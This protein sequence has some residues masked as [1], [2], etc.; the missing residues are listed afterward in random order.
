M[1][2]IRGRDTG[3]ERLLRREVW[4]MGLRYRLQHRIGRTR[5]DLV[6]LGARV[7]VFVDGCFWHGCPEHYVSPRSSR[8]FWGLKLQQNVTRDRDAT[9]R[10]ECDG[11]R[12]IRLWEHEVETDPRGSARRIERV[13]R[14]GATQ[15]DDC[16]RVIRVEFL[17]P[18]GARERRVLVP[19][20]GQPIESEKVQARSTAKWGARSQAGTSATRR[21]RKPS[22]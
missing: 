10:L 16:M 13:V 22:S 3:P 1:S 6:F 21:V 12:V 4:R 8:E 2:R 9:S 19:L 11:W 5:P 18:E 7:A 15:Q 20:R 17:D 14:G